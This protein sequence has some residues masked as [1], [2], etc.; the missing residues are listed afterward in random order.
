M[1][2]ILLLCL[3]LPQVA[4]ADY[5]VWEDEKSGVSL[6]YPDTWH[7]TSNQKPRDIFTVNGPND[8]FDRPSCRL[9]VVNDGRFG[10]FPPPY[11]RAVQKISY[12][13]AFWEDHISK[14]Y[15]DA[16][17]LQYGDN[18]G[19]GRAFGSYVLVDYIDDRHDEDIAM[20]A[21]SLAGI[22]GDNGYMFECT[23]KRDGFDK[24]QLIF[25]SIAASVDFQPIYSPLPHGYYRDFINY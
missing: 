15:K 4:Q 9:S 22:Y 16:R 3:A 25:Q 2:L 19:I 11:Y 20:R 5:F 6:S 14:H 21:L 23:A 13:R 18:A 8:F 24:W 10:V 12:S 7:I 1:C 17:V